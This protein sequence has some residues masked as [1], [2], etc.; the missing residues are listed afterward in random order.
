MSAAAPAHSAPAVRCKAGAYWLSD[1]TI[2]PTIGAL[3]AVHLPRRTDH[4]APRCLVADAVAGLIQTGFANHQKF[5]RNVHPQGARW[6]GGTFRCR[7]V[8]RQGDYNEYMHAT[9][10]KRRQHVTMDLGS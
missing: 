5:P 6:D 1:P 4:Y 8:L 9:C 2:F 10:S 3:R 7:Y